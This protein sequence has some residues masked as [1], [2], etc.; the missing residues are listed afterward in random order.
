MALNP[1]EL[2]TT[3]TG[4]GSGKRVMSTATQPKTFASG[5]GTLVKCTPVIYNDAT[6][7]WGV[8][9]GGAS[10][11]SRITADGTPA[12]DGTFT[13]TINGQTT[14]AIDHDAIA[15]VVET[16][17]EVLSTVPVGEATVAEFGGGLS[18][19]NDGVTIT[20]SGSLAQ[21][22]VQVTADFAALTGAAHVL[23]TDTA[24]TSDRIDGF[25]WPDDLVLDSDEDVLGQVMLRGRIHV[26]DIVL[27]ATETQGS[28]EA[29]LR[30]QQVR[31][32]GI[33]VEGLEGFH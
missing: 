33:I 30:D 22:D 20:F 10:E 28:L 15:S 5:S 14:T 12:T 4:I 6:L 1:N 27:P 25:L 32:S 26:G 9:T 7:L 23:S 2:L 13:I 18:D 29:A 3:A 21:Q 11:V 19:A 8:W 24:G 16:A 17:L 31:D